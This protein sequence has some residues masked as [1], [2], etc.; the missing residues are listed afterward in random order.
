M[1]TNEAF[2][3]LLKIME[4]PPAHLILIFATTEI[5]KVPQTI[6]SR[7]QR[8]EF[9]RIST[10]SI[11]KNLEKILKDLSI[12]KDDEAL[13]MIAENSGGAMRD[14][15][16]LLD[17]SIINGEFKFEYVKNNIGGISFN[18]TERLVSK[19][20][21]ND[22]SA[23]LDIVNLD[24][25]SL[26]IT[27]D[28]INIF[29]N[30]M[31]I[32]GGLSGSDIEISKEKEE[33]IKDLFKNVDMGRIVD[34]LEILI[35][36]ENLQKKSDNG[37]T[38]LELLII[39]LI[40][41]VDKKSLESRVRSL[42]SKLENVDGALS[43][44]K[45]SFEKI[46]RKEELKENIKRTDKEIIHKQGKENLVE[47]NHVEKEKENLI[48]SSSKKE[49]EKVSE[50]IEVDKSYKK[51]EDLESLYYERVDEIISKSEDIGISYEQN[52]LNNSTLFFGDNRIYFLFRE[53]AQLFFL[54]AQGKE[55][56]LDKIFKD[57]LGKNVNISIVNDRRLVQVEEKKDIDKET[58]KE[59]ENISKLKDFFGEDNLNII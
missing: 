10:N 15:V 18:Q 14:A 36:Y 33:N 12:E 48:T 2:N 6:L 31:L 54:I 57:V 38:L 17:Q 59:K 43:P 37:D 53:D 3:A 44:K 24:S 21:S 23:L 16:S 19:I 42:E 28:L 41:Y 35:E 22:S 49:N 8:F 30:G 32:K 9:K 26:G 25:D 11:K 20:L 50:K 58:N 46:T 45:N 4:E 40:N 51:N 1:I 27:R 55:D 29:R 56:E 52:M 34:S 13:D 7:A 47:E 5:E 39:R